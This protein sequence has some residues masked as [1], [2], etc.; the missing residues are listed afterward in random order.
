MF[1]VSTAEAEL[2]KQNTVFLFQIYYTLNIYP[3]LLTLPTRE[4]AKH[5]EAL[6]PSTPTTQSLSLSQTHTFT[7]FALN[8][9]NMQATNLEVNI[10]IDYSKLPLFTH[11]RFE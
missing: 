7:P 2:N 9:V 1:N 4:K 5:F 6:C 3:N 10:V 11:V 8:R